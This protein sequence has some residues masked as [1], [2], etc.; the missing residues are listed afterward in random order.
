VLTDAS[1]ADTALM[2][3]PSMIDIPP[4][5][6]YCVG[7]F[8]NWQHRDIGINCIDMIFMQRYMIILFVILLNKIFRYYYLQDHNK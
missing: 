4:D 5:K 6:H 2:N 3:V 7:E 1:P 8:Y